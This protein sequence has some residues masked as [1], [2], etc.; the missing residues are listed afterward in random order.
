MSELKDFQIENG[1][2]VKYL[3]NGGDIVIPNNVTKIEKYAFYACNN[4]ISVVIPSNVKTIGD[5]AFKC[6]MNLSV[7]TIENGI[8]RIGNGVFRECKNLKAVII[9]D[10]VVKIADTAFGR[11]TKLTIYGSKDSYAKNYAKEA[12]IKFSSKTS[13]KKPSDYINLIQK[14]TPSARM[15]RAVKVFENATK[16]INE[17]LEISGD[18]SV[19]VANRAEVKSIGNIEF[20]EVKHEAEEFIGKIEFTDSRLAEIGYNS[21][22]LFSEYLNRICEGTNSQKEQDLN[23]FGYELA[24]ALSV[25]YFVFVNPSIIIE[26]TIVRDKWEL[27]GDYRSSS[28][29]VWRLSRAEPDGKNASFCYEK[30]YSM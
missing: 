11:C 17:L 14:E 6:C 29:V 26:F 9:P 4:I 27:R 10:S 16:A 15:K 19:P 12:Y 22:D 28:S 2:L 8:K 25:A 23:G 7:V 24:V 1:V 30:G 5:L 21:K 18:F 13:V 3:G 20:E